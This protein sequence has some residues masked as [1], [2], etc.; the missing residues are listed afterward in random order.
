MTFAK[1]C[2][3]VIFHYG[4]FIFGNPHGNTGIR[5][6]CQEAHWEK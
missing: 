1:K 5:L 6:H 3:L 2:T 4:K